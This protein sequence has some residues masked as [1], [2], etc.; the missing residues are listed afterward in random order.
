MSRPIP[1][2][3]RSAQ[4][5]VVRVRHGNEPHITS[6]HATE[7]A[8]EFQVLRNFATDVAWIARLIHANKFSWIAGVTVAGETADSAAN[9]IG[10]EEM[11]FLQ[12]LSERKR[13]LE[14]G[15]TP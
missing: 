1:Q 7:Q 15:G 8:A 9:R 4:H 5:V 12:S 14:T 3:F 2:Y 11:D 6:I 13:A 10:A